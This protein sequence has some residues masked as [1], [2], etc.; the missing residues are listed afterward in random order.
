MTLPSNSRVGLLTLFV[1]LLVGCGDASDYR[2]FPQDQSVE[3]PFA[4]AAPW[5]VIEFEQPLQINASGTHGLHLLVDGA[6][7]A[8]NG[9]IDP[10]ADA[11]HQTVL[12]RLSDN[13]LVRPE[14]ILIADNGE[15]VAL[16]P[17]S[18]L[19]PITG[20]V[21]VGFSLDAGVFEPAPSFPDTIQ[22]FT[23]LRIRS[24]ETIDVHYIL[25]R[26]D[27]HPDLYRCLG[28]CPWWRFW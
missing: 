1:C 7:Y 12:L 9:M 19:W 28:E 14:V 22:E 20:G 11:E 8:S 15:E 24:D 13:T 18:N 3:G 25:W 27:H 2:G 10:S 16:S 23:A 5:Q 17:T 4:I 6:R 21:T 26:V